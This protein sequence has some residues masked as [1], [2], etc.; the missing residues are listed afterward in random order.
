VSE[1]DGAWVRLRESFIYAKE[2][3]ARDSAISG[4]MFHIY[5]YIYQMTD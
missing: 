5:I 3:G 4:Y 2:L 1:R